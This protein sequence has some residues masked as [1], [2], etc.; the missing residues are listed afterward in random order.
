MPLTKN[1]SVAEL[2]KP[3]RG[4]SIFTRAYGD[5]HSGKF[6]VYSAS[7]LAPLCCIST[8][9]Y[10]G[11]YLTW[12]T[13]G[14]GGRIQII[15]GKFSVNGDRGVLIPIGEVPPLPY[16]KH[17]LEPILIDSAIGRR[18]DG[19]KNDYT[20]IGPEVV[21][22]AILSLP[23]S[24]AG[25]LDFIQMDATAKKLTLIEQLR[26]EMQ[27]HSD[28]I[29]ATEI[30]IPPASDCATL[31]LGDETIFSMEI[32]ERLLSGEGL[33][34]GVPIYSANVFRPFT[35]VKTSNLKSFE[36]DSI[37]W[38]IDN[39]NF[40]WN[41]IPKGIVFATTDHCGRLLVKRDDLDPE[42]IY[43]FLQATRAQYGFDWS[44]RS[45]MGTIRALV[46]VDV[47]IDKEGNFDLAFQKALARR[48]RKL[49]ALK[50]DTMSALSQLAKARALL[51]A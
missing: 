30:L 47:P 43:Y 21:G 28:A 49:R 2:F 18:V 33:S 41:I 12:T 19:R 20:K 17:I 24:T 36:R 5:A 48:Y 1:I 27:K 7:L 26:V 3:V 45:S 25:D 14:Y 31:S 11:T 50:R 32:G 37:I 35:F 34:S 40:D 42:Y 22:Q 29:S 9:D 10:N 44:F 6:P 8:Y 51:A 46:T 4:K 23:V 16:V 15:S 39:A 13:N 38:T